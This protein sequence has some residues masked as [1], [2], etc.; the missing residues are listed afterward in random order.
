MRVLLFITDLQ[1]GGTPLRI[2]RLATGL[3]DL[4][5]DVHVGCLAMP[6]PVSAALEAAH[7]P[8]FACGARSI[9]SLSAL[10]RLAL[11]VRRIKPELIHSTLTHANV[12]ARLVGWW[13]G[14]PVIGSTATLEVER[15]SHRRL[16]RLTAGLEAA[17]V[18]NSDVLRNHVIRE[19]NRPAERV[20]VV[21]PSVR[22]FPAIDRSA[23]RK[24]LDLPDDA[25]IILWVGRFDPVKRLPLLLEAAAKL[26]HP[27]IRWLLIGDGPDR[28][29]IQALVRK[30]GLTNI[31]ALPGWQADLGPA[32]AAADLFAFPSLTE[33]MPNAL[34]E[35]LAAGVPALATS[36][37][38]MQA[39]ASNTP[40]IRLTGDSA[41]ELAASIAQLFGNE[42]ERLALRAAAQSGAALLPD[43]Q[44]TVREML[45]I[46]ESVLSG[47][48]TPAPPKAL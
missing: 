46:Y 42:S 39:L 35:S 30:L 29:R 6:G 47:S 17:H 36:N 16:E 40:G 41:N 20:H 31:A 2:A 8:T 13:T 34:L 14:I 9:L 19:F 11:H 45:K 5:V 32:F 12:A 28:I 21:P 48:T 27:R 43:P 23:A 3:R 4:G 38:T 7:V 18:V 25:F 22:R 26:Q 24:Q 37:P 15:R 33:G 10:P 1:P 44:E